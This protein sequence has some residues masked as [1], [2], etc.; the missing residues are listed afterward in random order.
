[1]DSFLSFQFIACTVLFFILI[2]L[3]PLSSR[4][5]KWFSSCGKPFNCGNINE[6]TYP[7][8]GNDRPKE[9]GYPG[10]ELQCEDQGNTVI[11]IANINYLVLDINLD[12]QI[13]TVTRKD[14]G[15]DRIC[16]F[17]STIDNSNTFEYASSL[18]NFTFNYACLPWAG[19]FNCPING[20]NY[21]NGFAIG[22]D[23]GAGTCHASIVVPGRK[24]FS[25]GGIIRDLGDLKQL[26]EQGFDVKWKVDRSHCKEC[27]KLGGRC[28]FDVGAKEFRCLCPE[29]QS[30]SSS[31]SN[32]A[33]TSGVPT[34]AVSSSGTGNSKP[35]SS[36][37][38]PPG[39]FPYFLLK[40]CIFR[41][42]I[43][44]FYIVD[45]KEFLT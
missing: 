1:M 34:G 31:S 44:N 16:Q 8:W 42:L 33:C 7:F 9:C 25:S 29:D 35:L 3:P 14:L 20:M 30:S 13:I 27:E 2:H 26:L 24:E 40:L 37:T 6:I 23:G 45:K 43:L 10:F 22:S 12:G 11:Q 4:E 39:T 41:Q 32:N 5:N 21:K 38:T 18:V 36:L 15:A 17:N 19:S 28:G